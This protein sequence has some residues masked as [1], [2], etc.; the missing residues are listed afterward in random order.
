M[1][2]FFVLILYYFFELFINVFYKIL[3]ANV[4]IKNVIHKRNSKKLQI[5]SR[6]IIIIQKQIKL[7]L[8][9]FSGR[10]I[11]KISQGTCNLTHKYSIYIKFCVNIVKW[12]K[13]RHINLNS[14]L[15]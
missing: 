1:K 7:Y 6:K 14:L 4:V 10:L 2:A 8:A 3:S 12:I 13:C 9:K 11:L 15:I 5:S